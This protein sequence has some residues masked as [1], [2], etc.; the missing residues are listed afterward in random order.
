MDYLVV[1]EGDDATGYGAYVP[2]LPGCIA[3]ADTR[4]EVEQLIREAV[5]FH[6]EGMAEVGEP[7]PVATSRAIMVEASIPVHA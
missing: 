2:D 5:P 7:I 3:A 6:I 4:E 1:I